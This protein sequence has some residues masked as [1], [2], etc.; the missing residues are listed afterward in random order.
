MEVIDSKLFI[1]TA[2]R[3]GKKRGTPLYSGKSHY[4]DENKWCKNVRFGP[5][6][7]VDENTDT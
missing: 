4:V 1:R 5:C 3:M 2:A 7:Y 6:H